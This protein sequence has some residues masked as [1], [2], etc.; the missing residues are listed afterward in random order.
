MLYATS[1]SSVPGPDRYAPRCMDVDV[2]SVHSGFSKYTS[3]TFSKA[4]RDQPTTGDF[5]AMTAPPTSGKQQFPYVPLPPRCLG[6]H[7]PNRFGGAS[8]WQTTKPTIAAALVLSKKVPAAAEV[9]AAVRGGVVEEVDRVMAAEAKAEIQL[10]KEARLVAETEAKKQE[11][12]R[13][14]AEELR[15]AA[16]EE[17]R[18]AA[19]A[20][21]WTQAKEEIDQGARVLA[22]SETF[23]SG[24]TDNTD[25][26]LSLS[27]SSDSDSSISSNDGESNGSGAD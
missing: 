18:L 14:A 7:A 11:E 8:S 25:S 15:I 26:S 23:M 5:V 21:G 1:R 17:A 20:G 24:D 3:T 13:L 9:K 6:S 12:E 16:E 27:L 4:R 22:E 2:C 19:E 10:Q